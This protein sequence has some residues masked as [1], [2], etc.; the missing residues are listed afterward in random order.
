MMVNNEYKMQKGILFSAIFL[1]LLSLSGCN[2]ESYESNLNTLPPL[3]EMNDHVFA[4][5]NNQ[6]GLL[7]SEVTININDHVRS[8]TGSDI[9]LKNVTLQNKSTCKVN[10]IQSLSFSVQTGDVDD[11]LFEYEVQSKLNDEINT[12]T[13]IVR[14]A[15]G[16]TYQN[17]ELPRITKKATLNNPISIDLNY[18]LLNEGI[19]PDDALNTEL[20][21]I[22]SGEATIANDNTVVFE[23]NNVGTAEI[24]YSYISSSNVKQGVISVSV[25]EE[26]ENTPPAVTDFEQEGLINL[27]DTV[28]IDVSD[29]VEDING[30]DIQ[31]VSIDDFNSSS[32][33]FAPTDINNTQFYFNASVPG[34]H[35]VAYTVSDHMGGYSTGLVHINVEPDFSLIQDWEDIVTYDPF[36]NSDIRFFAPMTKV[37]ADY[38]NANYTETN[39]EDGTYGENGAEVVQMSLEQA[40]NYCKTRGGRLPLTRELNTLFTTE[41]NLYLQHNWPTSQAYWTAEKVSEQDASTFILHNG[42]LSNQDKNNTAYATCV[43]LSNEDVKDFS[44]SVSYT[45]G[46][47]NEY[48][49]TIQTI[50]PDGESAPF[51]DIDLTA[52]NNRGVFDNT[53]SIKNVITDQYGLIIQLYYDTS[54]Q[55]EVII[56]SLSASDDRYAFIP[57]LENSNI[58]LT[59]LDKWSSR[60]YSLAELMLSSAD[61]LP[62]LYSESNHS[63][64]TYIDS[65][66][67]ENFI[68]YYR[69]KA[70]DTINKG[71][72]SFTLQQVTNDANMLT[73]DQ[74][75]ISNG[76]IRDSS[77]F[78]FSTNFY[79]NGYV[80]IDNGELQG[81]FIFSDVR[82]LYN[83]VW[84][85]KRGNYVEVYSS[86]SPERPDE[87][88][89][90]FEISNTHFDLSKEFW[91]TFGG[92]NSVSSDSSA[93]NL[94]FSAY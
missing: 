79:R 64:S 39:I 14:L 34:S 58:D 66:L 29:Y 78:G 86:T 1:S 19:D 74:I 56:V 87:P 65:F 16:E 77:T 40:R 37:Y 92:F 68:S 55:N 27:E 3:P 91:I 57:V 41:G 61:G 43:D 59:D 36:I 10:S 93:V 45:D 21:I 5:N 70:S 38:V 18:E 67:G 72:V 83:Y 60:Q 88:V 48:T 22:G 9:E 71:A 12:T 90:V 6:Q 51:V 42:I 7:N 25:S 47:G 20:T 46:V 76:I 2:D 54:F 85:D 53:L 52:A 84:F 4:E 24:F 11:C 89:G 26:G 50:N 23:P 82:T 17:E 32:S 30:D 75:P 62:L 80:L 81:D 28:V 13:A 8:T 63:N 69:L 44:S 35:D 33:L 15:V 31:L 94:Y 49:Y 73:D